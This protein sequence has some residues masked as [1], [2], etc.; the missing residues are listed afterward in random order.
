MAT[1]ERLPA[2][3]TSVEQIARISPIV[4]DSSNT[5][6]STHA[7]ADPESLDHRRSQVLRKPPPV[8]FGAIDIG[9]NSIHLVMVEI[10]PEG[11]F[12]ILGRDKAMVQLGKGGFVQHVLTPRAIADGLSTLSR[13]QKM[14]QLKGIHRLRSVATSAV[15]EST[16]G[17]DFVQAARDTLGMD[18][19]VL[20]VEEEARLIYLA[21]RHST[22]LGL[23]EN[24]IVDIG[25]GS[26]ELIVGNSVKPDILCSTKLGSLRLSE[27][28]IHHDPPSADDIKVMRRH[29]EDQLAPIVQRIGKRE[30][31]R[32]IGTSGTFQML[33]QV[34]AQ[35]RGAGETGPTTQ[36]R[37]SRSDLKELRT[38]LGIMSR[39]DRL[40]IPGVDEKRVDTLYPSTVLLLTIMRLLHTYEFEYCD[41]AM[42]EGII[43][44]H[45]ARQRAHL[46]ARAS[47][48][49]P[50]PRSVIQLAERCGYHRPHAE[51]VARLALM[52]FD[53]LKS[54]HGMDDAMRDL[55]KFACMLHDVGY[56]ISHSQHHKHSYYLIR[57]GRLQGFTE[58]EI[59][60][61][62]NIARYH[63]K[64]RPRKSDYSYQ[65]LAK[66][67]RR[68]VKKLIAILR[69]ANALDRTHYSVVDSVSCR[70]KPEGVEVQVHTTKDAELELWMARHQAAFFE[71][72]FET[73]LIVDI[74][75]AATEQ[76]E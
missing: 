49:D 24:L 60:I 42:R 37:V 6:P 25:G 44:D 19:H 70:I 72:E 31:Q 50:R 76:R 33:S 4:S 3:F 48:P 28:F 73:P 15:R 38:D 66:E 55:L 53:Q 30:F 59:E 26:V 27:L 63:R 36:L 12:R 39:A 71:R 16:N 5:A 51:Q 61:L 52:L 8:K 14:A 45:I 68:P 13:F 43:I 41:M 23:A 21:V 69:L 47:W 57:N 40:K 56:L 10:S 22:D 32:C 35:R 20:S 29:I 54:L 62:A 11:D 46:L 67:S 17:G 9:T 34:C 2:T 74:A 58:Q 7:V 64:G 65:H 18:I 1:D 75:T